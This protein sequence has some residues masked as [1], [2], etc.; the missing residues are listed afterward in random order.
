MVGITKTDYLL[1]RECPKNAWLKVHKPDIFYASELTEFDKSLIDSGLEVEEIARA[2][3]HD[4]L[5]IAGR[6]EEAQIATQKHLDAGVPTLFQ[7][8]FELDGFLAA[9]DVLEFSKKTG[10]YTIREI[11]SS[12]K[13]K[14]EHLYDIAFQTLLLQRCGLK[15]EQVFL[16]HLNPD[17]VRLG[18]LDLTNL[19]ASAD[20]SEKVAEIA[21]TITQEIEE[22]RDFL[23]IETEPSGSCPCIYKGR[24]QHCSTFRYSNPHVPEYSVHDIS[25]IGNSPKK[26][27]QMIDA[28]AFALEDI[29]THIELSDIQKAQVSAYKSGETAITKEAIADE[30]AKLTFPLHFVDY[31]TYPSAI[32][33][34]DRY[35]PY[36]HIP[37]QYSLHVVKSLGEE[38]VHLEFLHVA[39]EDPSEL[40]VRS[41]QE[42]VSSTGSIIVWNKT[43]ESGINK[44]ISLRFPAFES[45]V[46]SL[47]DRIYDLKD[48]FSKQYYVHKDFLGKV[49]KSVV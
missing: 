19:F 20:V 23:L 39:M 4:G 26:L 21:A 44:H 46:A 22:A 14:E 6:D 35:S 36:H 47:N 13:L 32:P 18:E 2:L 34:F 33:L 40:F 31:E 5:L 3:F 27:K 37:F 41:L 43:F 12:T 11:K 42:N 25:R 8:I 7:P 17:Y 29:P 10:S 15:I 49:W 30:L 48:I 9:V 45:F 24:S 16:V 1:W 38:P 28:G